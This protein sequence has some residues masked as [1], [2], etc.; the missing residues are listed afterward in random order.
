MNISF[1][2]Y[3]VFC[4]VSE[5]KSITNASKKL[6]ISQP[7]IT[8]TIKI[9][10]SEINS[11]LFYRTHNGMT[12]TSEGEKLYAYIKPIILQLDE[13]KNMMSEIITNGKT[14]IRIGTS[15]TVLRFF[16]IDFIKDY[17]E[18]HPNV[19][20]NVEDN[21]NNNLI[22]KIKEGSIDIAVIT[23]TANYTNKYTDIRRY[24]IKDLNYGFF[25]SKDYLPKNETPINIKKIKNKNF[26]INKNTTELNKFHQ[27]H[28]LNNFLSVA[29][30]SLIIDFIK[31]G[32]G[33]GL[34]IKEFT[35][36]IEGLHEIKI[37]EEL[38]KAELVALTNGNKYHN[39]AV[40]HFINELT[41]K[42]TRV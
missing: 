41:T 8:K 27:K 11:T 4:T 38:P 42:K 31:K 21:T 15:I 25:C 22:T 20:I 39:I 40:S 14:N 9:L 2:Y 24:K 17:M 12:L 6:N 23:S 28:E 18:E 29:S 19:L 10:E 13:T 7:A 30:N 3:R 32:V 1:E 36:N 5:C 33:L 34:V 16:L 37:K 26:I 35:S